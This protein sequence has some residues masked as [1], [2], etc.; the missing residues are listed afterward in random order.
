MLEKR[1]VEQAA[2][3]M[4]AIE[5]G[6]LFPYVPDAGENIYSR[7]EQ[8]NRDFAKKGIRTVVIKECSEHSSTLLL[9]TYRPAM[10]QKILDRADSKTFL[11]QYG[12]EKDF[13]LGEYLQMLSAR[14]CP[15]NPFPHEIGL[16][17]GYPLEDVMGFIA[18]KGSNYLCCGHWKVYA[19]RE[20]A[21]KQFTRF[22]RCTKIFCESYNS[23]ISI[24]QLTVAV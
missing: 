21:E 22:R 9:Y 7:L 20:Q 16:F 19:N 1:L 13:S 11:M 18:N 10:M 2:P 12:Y 6:S 4:A 23:G 8:W 3:T 17:L 14:L 24:N 15:E 5:V